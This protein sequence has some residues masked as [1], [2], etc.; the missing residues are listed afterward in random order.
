M[1]VRFKGVGIDHALFEDLSVSLGF[2]DRFQGFGVGISFDL[3]GIMY[4]DDSWFVEG[5]SDFVDDVGFEKVKVQLGL[6]AHVE[7]ESAYLTFHFSVLGSVA[8]IFRASRRKLDDVIPRF[9]FAGKFAEIVS[10]GIPLCG[11]TF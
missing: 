10:R 2:F 11:L 3:V 6:S 1:G 5:C 9:Q 4:G 8:V 7:G